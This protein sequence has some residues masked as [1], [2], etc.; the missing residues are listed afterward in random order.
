M[1]RYAWLLCLAGCFSDADQDGDGFGTTDC[2]DTDP[3]IYPNAP[4]RCNDIDD[5]CDGVVDDNATDALTFFADQDADGFGGVETA[6]AC[7]APSGFVALEGDCDD[8]AARVFPGAPERCN[9]LDDDCDGSAEDVLFCREDCESGIDDD[10]D[11]LVDCEDAE[12][13]ALCGERECA[14]GL[15][16]DDDGAL[17]CAD[18]DCWGVGDCAEGL[19]RVTGGT[20]AVQ[21]SLITRPEGRQ[22]VFEVDL[23]EVAGSA[24]RDGERCSWSVESARFVF[25]RATESGALTEV[26]ETVE[27]G[28]VVTDCASL[29]GLLP[30]FLE[31]DAVSWAWYGGHRFETTSVTGEETDGGGQIEQT[32][33][34]FDALGPGAVVGGCPDGSA[35]LQFADEDGDGIGAA[36]RLGCGEAAGWVAIGGDCDDADAQVKPGAVEVC[37]NGLDDDCDGLADCEGLSGR[38]TDDAGWAHV[39]GEADGDRA[40][41]VVGVGDLDGDGRADWAVGAKDSDTVGKDAG[42]VYLFPGGLGGALRSEDAQATIRGTTGD[43]LG[44]AL[45]GV[46]D[47]DGDGL[48][49]IAI[50]A[51]GVDGGDASRAGAVFF[52]YGPLDGELTTDGLSAVR[53]D[54]TLFL[55]AGVASAGDVDGDGRPDVW[56]GATADDRGGDIAGSIS[57][58]PGPVEGD[59]QLSELGTVVLGAGADAKIG[60]VFAS[61]D[62]DGDA[63]PDLVIGDRWSESG[64]PDGGAVHLVTAPSG[65]M[66]TADAQATWSGGSEDARL[67]ATVAVG[68]LDL[69]GYDEIIVAAPRSEGEQPNVEAPRGMVFVIGG[70]AETIGGPVEEQASATLFGERIWD[71]AGTCLAVGDLDQNG[72][73][74]LFIG[75]PGDDENGL[76]SGVVYRL[77]APAGTRDLAE[78]EDRVLGREALWLTGSS[79]AV[80]GDVDGD[81][82]PDLGVGSRALGTGSDRGAVGILRGGAGW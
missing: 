64:A 25:A 37:G 28:G 13:H 38:R 40:R 43:W 82:Y 24:Y 77:E 60:E 29:E 8:Q 26:Q 2:D 52:A 4:E 20:A 65:V 78:V 66:S 75:A 23:F 70:G 53:G 50:G 63:V 49:D 10:G 33:W 17:D 56:V 12:C 68:D 14:N 62:V 5:D 16:D 34:Y 18:P 71:E 3:T 46:G 81:A 47:L 21:T 69:D 80:L 36:S 6:R 30:P 74:E 22:R 32:R 15:D 55:G 44:G 72:V 27:R 41:L 61:G 1:T 11:G 45:A 42:A 35:G 31:P 54:S 48:D 76:Y 51:T 73:P 67:G 9:G 58:V 39:E 59:V 57:L 7:V 19:A 79:C